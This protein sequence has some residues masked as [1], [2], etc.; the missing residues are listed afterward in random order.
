MQVKC[1]D[2]GAG[3]GEGGETW[4]WGPRDENVS[5]CE[6]LR[7]P[8]GSTG[9]GRGI[10]AMLHRSEE[11][12]ASQSYAYQYPVS[13]AV[14]RHCHPLPG[15]TS[16]ATTCG[17]VEVEWK[18]EALNAR[19]GVDFVASRGVLKWA[20]GDTLTKYIQV[21]VLR[22]AARPRAAEFAVQLGLSRGAVV[23]RAHRATRIRLAR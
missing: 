9:E 13:I 19:A 23:P 4:G 7:A 18:T 2:E 5:G 22:A 12:T 8:R 15:Q 16:A 17:P 20:G 11:V 6:A 21:Y 10:V 1:S 3:S 14:Q